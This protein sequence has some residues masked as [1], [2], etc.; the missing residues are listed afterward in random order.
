[1]FG[2]S[3]RFVP[4]KGIY[5]TPRFPAQVGSG[6]QQVDVTRVYSATPSLE[7]WAL[8]RPSRAHAGRGCTDAISASRDDFGGYKRGLEAQTGGTR[9]SRDSGAD[10]AD[11]VEA[12]AAKG[13]LRNAR[14]YHLPRGYSCALSQAGRF[15][16][17]DAVCEYFPT[18]TLSIYVV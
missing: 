8:L 7:T 14:P 17:L 9:F 15:G 16:R 2:H 11:L 4:R 13:N 3:P 6:L 1:M 10:A 5:A 12:F 18:F